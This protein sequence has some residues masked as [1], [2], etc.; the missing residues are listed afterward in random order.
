MTLILE[1]IEKELK[2]RHQ[3]SY[4]WFRKQNDTWD[5]YTNFIYQT[6]SWDTL[7][8]KLAILVEMHDFD[9]Q[10]V[11]QYAANRWYNF[12]S[13]QAVEQIFTEIEG[14]DPIPEAKDSEKDFYLFGIPFDHKTS[15]FPKQFNQTF[16][17]AQTHKAELIEWLYKNQ[18]TQKRHHFKNRLFIVVYAENGE[19]WKLKAE[20]GLLKNAIQKYIAT[21][22]PEQLQSFTFVA[23]QQTLTDI[24]WVSK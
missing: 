3:Y 15:V 19:H 14:I 16:E 17:Y 18:S 11:F 2:R 22:R 24:I 12:W 4:K 20:I 10:Q 6:S 21:F 13:A 9:K 23:G 8:R 1:N 5:N 7:I